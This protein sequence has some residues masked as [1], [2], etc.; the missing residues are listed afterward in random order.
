MTTASH[1][2]VDSI[3]TLRNSYK[4]SVKVRMVQLYKSISK[5]F[6]NGGTREAVDENEEAKPTE[7]GKK[8]SIA[9][10]FTI[11]SCSINY[12]MRG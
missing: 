2:E 9:G 6:R 4:T 10:F 12:I 1:R 7:K 11:V 5:I 3:K 8:K